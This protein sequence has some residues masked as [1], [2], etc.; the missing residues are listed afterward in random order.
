MAKT[1]YKLSVLKNNIDSEKVQKVVEKNKVKA[2]RSFFK[3]PKKHDVHVE[4][5]KLFYEDFLILSGKYE[6]EFVRNASYTVSVNNNVKQIII[7]GVTFPVEKKRGVLDKIGISSDNKI[8][9]SITVEELVNMVQEDE[10]NFDH[11]GKPVK[12]PYKIN[13][14]TIESYPKKVLKKYKNSLRSSE[15]SYKKAAEELLKKL[16]EKTKNGVKDLK[17]KFSAV[18]VNEAYVPVYEARIIGPNKKVALLRVD[19]ITGKI[20]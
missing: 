20:L 13:S 11:H 2:V 6:A 19:G 12:F 18:N 4:S 10:I 1:H 14:E 7:D 3:E 5:I 17:E 9:V 16:K 8:P 15:I